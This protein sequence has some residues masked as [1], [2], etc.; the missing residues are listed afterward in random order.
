M[1]YFNYK[2]VQEGDDSQHLGESSG[3]SGI[4]DWFSSLPEGTPNNEDVSDEPAQLIDI[5]DDIHHRAFSGGII[6]GLTLSP[7]EYIC[8]NPDTQSW[9]EEIQNQLLE[10]TA[11]VWCILNN[12]KS[13][14]T[15]ETGRSVGNHP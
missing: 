13:D 1:D 11:F 7:P 12:V 9:D 8:K 15:Q 14:S 5:T 6:K 4:E 3:P 2:P 10:R